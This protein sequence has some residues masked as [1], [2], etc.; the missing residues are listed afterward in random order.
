MKDGVRP[1]R[2]ICC[3]VGCSGVCLLMYNHRTVLGEKYQLNRWQGKIHVP[4]TK[5]LPL[6]YSVCTICIELGGNGSCC[7]QSN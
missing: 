7:P 1:H 5:M 2:T 3:V 4:T 6:D